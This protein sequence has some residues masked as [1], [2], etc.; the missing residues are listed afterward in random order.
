MLTLNLLPA[1]KK[2]ETIFE[3]YRRLAIFV[4][5]ILF[6]YLIIFGIL[7]TSIYFFLNIQLEGLHRLIEAENLTVM[8]VKSRELESNVRQVRQKLEML[9]RLQEQNLPMAG[10][11]ESLT[12]SAPEGIRFKSVS[13]KKDAKQ[14][15]L[16]GRADKRAD[17]LNFKDILERNS[18]FAEV[19]VPI[20][21]LLKQ[22]D[23]DFNINF[24]LAR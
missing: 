8:A 16:S 15:S 9:T 7:L 21:I 24:K 13:I 20:S 14:V 4:A 12:D 11:L 19:S 6:V 22:Q 1:A 5:S 2:Q 23:I 18:D 17:L 10:V 3:K